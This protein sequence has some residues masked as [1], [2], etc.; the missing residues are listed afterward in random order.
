MEQKIQNIVAEV[1]NDTLE[2][3]AFLFVFPDE[4]R[5]DDGPQPAMTG[6]VNF[7]GYFSGSLMIRISTSAVSELAVNMLGLD[8]DT[9]IPSAEEQDAFKEMINVVCGNILPAIAGNQVEFSI[10]APEI[11]SES[12]S[13]AEINK[14]K[15]LCVVRL[16]LE[17]GFCDVYFFI[18][19][20]LPETI[21]GKEFA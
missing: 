15:P 3:L 7:S 18:E 11:L 17:D 6:R 1:A 19:G 2:K 4:E 8:D 10:G 13:E 14:E 16:M 5:V 20:E 21:G 9:E 12:D